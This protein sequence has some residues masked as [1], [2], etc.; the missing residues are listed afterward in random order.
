MPTTARQLIG[1]LIAAGSPSVAADGMH[2]VVVVRR[3]D[4]TANA[5]RSQLWLATADGSVAPRPL[6]AGE[7]NDRT[8]LISPDGRSVAF[9]S[10]RSGTDGETTLHL[11]RLDGPGETVTLATRPEDITGLAWSPD[12]RWLAFTSRERD[13]VY[14]QDDPK[15]RPPRRIS[16]FLTRLNGVGWTHDRPEHV[17]V[18]PADGTEAAFDVTPGEFAF[19]RPTW[20]A[21]SARVVVSGRGHP[22]WDTDLAI[23]LHLVDLDGHRRGLTS[24]TGIYLHAAA[25]PDGDLVAFLGTDDPMVYPQNVHVGVIDIASGERRWVSRALDRTFLL[26]A[27]VRAPV[28]QDG[29]IYACAEDHG[30]ARVHRL[31]PTGEQPPEPITPAGQVVSGFDAGGPTLA[32]TAAT[33]DRP[34]ELFAFDL[35]GRS[36][37][38]RLTSLNERFVAR[39]SPIP[40]ERFTSPS[41]DGVE[42]DTWVYLPSGFDPAGSW[43]VLLAVHGGPFTQYGNGYF[44]EAQLLAAAGFLVVLSNPRGS[45]GREESWG[46]AI[47]G[48]THPTHPGSGWGSVDAAD[49]L[50]A[51]DETLRRYPAADPTRVGMLGGSYGGYMATWLAAH[52]GD[53][54]RAI[55]SE[56]AVNNLLSEEWNADIAATFHTELG[57]SH[58]RVPQEYL[59]MSPITYVEQIHTPMLLIHSEDDLRCPITQAEELFVALRLLGREVSFVRFP[60]EDHELSRAGSPVHR[61]QRAELILEF[62]ASHLQ[63]NVADTPVGAV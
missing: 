54:F 17:F 52:H 48:P 42:V 61:V 31:D 34:A 7:R 5:Y 30:D 35:D 39:T 12:G 16:T 56:R 4:L 57:D 21:D 20:L 23:D 22:S 27:G 60:A 55:C 40:A 63:P 53:R 2:V 32:Y 29:S 46:Q 50:A 26:T 41:S 43:P 47:M 13:E 28:W 14:E 6:T 19:D 37:R 36:V 8:P 25:A 3:V 44:D 62:F 38:R 58:L 10:S 33:T 49:V 24:Q 51:L 1:S 15:R 18:V 11:L 59:R 9:V 45:S